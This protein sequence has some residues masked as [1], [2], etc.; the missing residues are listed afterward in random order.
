MISNSILNDF[1]MLTI[2]MRLMSAIVIHDAE[3]SAFGKT[4]FWWFTLVMLFDL[5]PY[6]RDNIV[7]LWTNLVEV[8]LNTLGAC[9]QLLLLVKYVLKHVEVCH[10]GT[11]GRI[12]DGSTAFLDAFFLAFNDF[13][14]PF[15]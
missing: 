8:V 6:F 15:Q 12:V 14:A 3:F 7:Y 4:Y 1:F 10:Y 9:L 2:Q 5:I 11:D 13:V